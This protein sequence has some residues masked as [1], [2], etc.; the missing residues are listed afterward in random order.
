[1]HDVRQSSPI[2]D[3][4]NL[5]YDAWH[6]YLRPVLIFL[7]RTKAGITIPFA[8]RSIVSVTAPIK[9]GFMVSA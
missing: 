2:R 8:A 7:K 9:L 4:C 6:M 1:M 3:V 5:R